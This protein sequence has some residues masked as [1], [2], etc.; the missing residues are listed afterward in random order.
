MRQNSVEYEHENSEPAQ[1]DDESTVGIWEVAVLLVKISDGRSDPK[2]HVGNTSNHGSLG[3]SCQ[4]CHQI[5]PLCLRSVHVEDDDQR[6]DDP[7]QSNEKVENE[8]NYFGVRVPADKAS[9]ID[10]QIVVVHQEEDAKRNERRSVAKRNVNLD[11]SADDARCEG[12]KM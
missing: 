5:P 4:V 3:L 1:Q 6:K 9:R 12:L 7:D 10:A 11:S 2:D 8:I